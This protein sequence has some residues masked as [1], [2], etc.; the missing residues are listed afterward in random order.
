M[1]ENENIIIKTESD[2]VRVKEEDNSEDSEPPMKKS[3]GAGLFQAFLDDGDDDDIVITGSY[4]RTAKDIAREE[5][6]GYR[7][8]PRH[9]NPEKPLHFWKIHATRFPHLERLA[10]KYLCAQAT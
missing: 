6:Q 9:P 1:T 5:V 4:Q 10:K 8:A 7:E 3:R 2:E